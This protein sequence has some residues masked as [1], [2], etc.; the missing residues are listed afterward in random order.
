[1]EAVEEAAGAAVPRIAGSSCRH[2][3]AGSLK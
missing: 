1:V 2:G 3:L